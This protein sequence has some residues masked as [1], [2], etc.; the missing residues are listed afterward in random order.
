LLGWVIELGRLA[1]NDHRKILNDDETL[2]P[3]AQ[4]MANPLKHMQNAHKNKARR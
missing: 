4:R 2:R 3:F 1:L